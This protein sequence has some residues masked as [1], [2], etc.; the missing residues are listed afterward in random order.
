MTAAARP[1]R[2]GVTAPAGDR[3]ARHAEQTPPAR[4]LILKRVYDPPDAAD[5]VRILVDRL[6][7]RGVRKEAARIDRWMRDLAPSPALRQWFGHDPARWEEF[8]RRYRAELAARTEALEALRALAR[9]RPVTLVHA[10]RDA[11][12]N[13]AVALRAALLRRKLPPEPAPAGDQGPDGR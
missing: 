9:Q 3:A 10:A 7:P 2:S 6:W 12:H 1:G 8:C 11:R 13:N 5:G 4:S